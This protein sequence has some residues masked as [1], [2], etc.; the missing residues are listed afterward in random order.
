MRR[1]SRHLQRGEQNCWLEAATHDKATQLR[2]FGRALISQT[3]FKEV[4]CWTVGCPRHTQM[5]RET[6]AWPDRTTE[7]SGL[8][9]VKCWVL[10]PCS[11]FKSL[12]GGRV[13][14][15]RTV[16]LPFLAQ[17]AANMLFICP[18][19]SAFPPK[20]PPQQLPLL[21]LHNK[22]TQPLRPQS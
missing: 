16:T 6:V 7:L 2:P 1:I 12:V 11:T 20:P 14:R 8:Q 5:L 17:C 10:P 19:Q 15:C 18:S 21:S 13:G 22:S 9:P 4:H 3:G